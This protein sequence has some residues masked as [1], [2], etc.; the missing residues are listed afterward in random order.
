MNDKELEALADLTR[1][2]SR[3][4]KSFDRSNSLKGQKARGK[5]YVKGIIEGLEEK[6]LMDKVT[7]I[8]QG[9]T[10]PTTHTPLPF[11]PY[12]PTPQPT[13]MPP[14][15]IPNPIPNGSWVIGPTSGVEVVD[16]QTKITS[17]Q[18]MGK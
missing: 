15:T 18:L 4:S 12:T 11:V 14:L 16:N 1:A 17:V 2:V 10:P 8:L 5:A 13:P 7:K 9:P 6:N 3:L